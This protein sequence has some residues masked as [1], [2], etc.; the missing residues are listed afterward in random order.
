LLGAFKFAGISLAVVLY[1]LI[2]VVQLFIK[3]TPKAK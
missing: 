3:S 1:I 2:S